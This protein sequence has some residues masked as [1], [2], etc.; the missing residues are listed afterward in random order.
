LDI[1]KYANF[2]LTEEPG[3]ERKSQ[4][5][6]LVIEL[7][8]KGEARITGM[9]TRDASGALTEAIGGGSGNGSFYP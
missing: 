2:E 1:G 3:H 6:W 8:A 7:V 9:Y 4:D 5:P